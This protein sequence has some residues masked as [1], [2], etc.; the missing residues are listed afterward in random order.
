MSGTV[1]NILTETPDGFVVAAPWAS[2]DK[3][4]Y[5]DVNA[6][7]SGVRFKRNVLSTRNGAQSKNNVVLDQSF[8]LPRVAEGVPLEQYTYT[9]VPDNQ[10]TIVSANRAIELVLTTPNGVL[11]LGMN[12][13]F[14]ITSTIVSLRFKNLANLGDAQINLIVV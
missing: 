6:Y 11:N 2:T 14:I 13:I 10:M 12:T 1:N 9:A 7:L 5:V 8:L 4:L 3:V